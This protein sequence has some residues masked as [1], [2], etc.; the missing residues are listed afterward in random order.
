MAEPTQELLL[1]YIDAAMTFYE[2]IT[3][4]LPTDKQLQVLLAI[5]GV[6]VELGLIR[7]N[8]EILRMLSSEESEQVL[9]QIIDE[10]FSLAEPGPLKNTLWA[11]YQR[12]NRKQ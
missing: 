5:A 3:G 4:K 11:R 6:H 2:R 1:G 7:T 12:L 10:L 8:A 9:R